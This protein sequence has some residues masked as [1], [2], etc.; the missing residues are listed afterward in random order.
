MFPTAGSFGND[1][2]FQ[3]T[4]AGRQ[5]R[6][7]N[8]ARDPQNHMG[9]LEDLDWESLEWMQRALGPMQSMLAN[10]VDEMDTDS[11]S[12]SS[13][14]SGSSSSDTDGS[15]SDGS[16]QSESSS[17][18]SDSDSDHDDNVEN[19][20]II[21]NMQQPGA[22]DDSMN[23]ILNSAVMPSSSSIYSAPVVPLK[24]VVCY[25]DGGDF[26]SR[27]PVYNLLRNDASVYCSNRVSNVNIVFRYQPSEFASDAM[28]TLKSFVI[29]APQSGYTA[30]CKEGIIFVSNNPIDPNDTA[31]FNDFTRHKFTQW[32]AKRSR[33]AAGNEQL[34]VEPIAFFQLN[35]CT[36]YITTHELYMPTS[37]RYI[38][39]K[40][41]RPSSPNPSRIPFNIDLQFAGFRGHPG[42]RSI[43]FGNI[44]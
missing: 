27:Y 43:S 39:L 9:M 44:N 35:E 11:S 29:K 42:K 28:F 21:E 2:Q 26:S 12:S 5:R 16:S 36:N 40:L 37:G 32:I 34:K 7:G 41:L 1:S 24:F 31:F 6:R 17:D 38:M 20:S 33:I 15:S 14:S 8:Q 23:C 18:S 19:R 4:S 22:A 3:A 10:N 25:C 30:P 13:S